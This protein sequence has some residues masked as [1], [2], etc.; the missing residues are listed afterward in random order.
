VSVAIK[1]INDPTDDRIACYHRKNYDFRNL[2]ARSLA[3]FVQMAI[4]RDMHACVKGVWD[5]HNPLVLLQGHLEIFNKL[6]DLETLIRQRHI[7]DEGDLATIGLTLYNFPTLSHFF[8]APKEQAFVREATVRELFDK[9]NY[10]RTLV[11]SSRLVADVPEDKNCQEV[12]EQEALGFV[13]QMTPATVEKEAGLEEKHVRKE[14]F[15]LVDMAAP[16]T[17]LKQ[18][19]LKLLDRESR[20]KQGAYDDWE[21]YGILPYLDLR[22]WE[23]LNIKVKAKTRVELIYPNRLHGYGTKK[24]DETTLPHLEKLMDEKGP[25][26]RGLLADASDEFWET[27]AWARQEDPDVNPAMAEEVLTRWFPRTYPFNFPDLER[28]ARLLPERRDGL[29]KMIEWLKNETQQRSMVER[30][31]MMELTEDGTGF[32]RA[33]EAV[34]GKNAYSLP[35]LPPEENDFDSDG[36]TEFLLDLCVCAD[37][38]EEEAG[39]DRSPVLQ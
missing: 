8:V 24:I 7:I 33:M 17:I 4:R 10:I 13:N 2:K 14:K 37:A 20:L 32:L 38:G 36:D 39:D 18:Q 19:F 22:Q 9:A 28:T 27:L 15:L 3:W 34:R 26:F 30:I 16:V 23:E 12:S 6:D 25:V 5:S 11:L 31:R 1:R 21:E 35:V 29:Q